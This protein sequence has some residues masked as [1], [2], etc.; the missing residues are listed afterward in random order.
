MCFKIQP[1]PK[2][3][4]VFVLLVSLETKLGL[5]VSEVSGWF[6]ISTR[7]RGSTPHTTNWGLPEETNIRIVFNKW[8][9]A[10][11]RAP[12]LNPAVGELSLLPGRASGSPG[13]SGGVRCCGAGGQKRARGGFRGSVSTSGS[14]NRFCPVI[15]PLTR[16]TCAEKNGR[17]QDLSPPL[18]PFPEAS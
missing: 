5:V 15:V 2:N 3:N 13:G 10:F 1:P 17:P 14:F 9:G 7:N 8:V 11:V 18:R 4:G 16:L 6:S 12:S